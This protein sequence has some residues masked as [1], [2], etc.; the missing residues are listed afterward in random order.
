MAW[1]SSSCLRRRHAPRLIAKGPREQRWRVH[2]LRPQHQPYDD[3]PAQA[4]LPERLRQRRALSFFAK[5]GEVTEKESMPRLVLQE[6]AAQ[7]VLVLNP[8]VRG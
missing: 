4:S 5:E 2:H 3:V 6:A 1:T 8:V 7:Q